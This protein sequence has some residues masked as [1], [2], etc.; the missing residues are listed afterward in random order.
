MT[1]SD[2]IKKEHK[3]YIV[4]EQ[5]LLDIVLSFYDIKDTN[6]NN[7]IAKELLRKLGVYAVQLLAVDMGYPLGGILKKRLEEINEQLKENKEIISYSEL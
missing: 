1:D 2:Y 7:E 5:Y 3:K 4:P 6:G